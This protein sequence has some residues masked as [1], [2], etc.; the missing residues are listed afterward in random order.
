M[1]GDSASTLI[2]SVKHFFSGTMISRL[3]GLLRDISMAF[4]FGTQESVA[5]FLMAFRFAHLLRRLFGEGAMQ[6]AFTPFF[7]KLKLISPERASRFFIDLLATLS[8][9]L[10][11]IVIVGMAGCSVILRNGW[12]G[13]GNAQVLT[14]TLIMLPSLLFICLFGLNASLLQCARSYFLPSVS[15]VLFNLVWTG[16]ALLLA[17]VPVDE[18]MPVLSGFIIIACAC[19]WGITVPATIRLLK[20][21]DSK[22]FWH[23]IRLFSPDIKQLL[24]PLLLAIVG[25]SAAQINN[26]MDVIFA[27]YASSE[28]PAYLWYAIRLQQL[29][30]ALFGVGV[31]GALLPPLSRALKGGNLDL[32][33]GH[34]SFAV[35]RCT[36]LM[37]PMTAGIFL[38]GGASIQLLYG[39][40]GFGQESIEGTTACL[41]GYSIG[42]LPMTL[43]L[44]LA[45]AF[46]AQDNFRIPTIASLVSMSVN[47]LL[48]FWFIMGLGLGAAS[49]ALSTSLSA[50]VNVIILGYY[51]R[52]HAG[53]V[54]NKKFGVSMLKTSCATLAAATACAWLSVSEFLPEGITMHPLAYI[55]IQS[56][57]FTTVFFSVAYA[58]EAEDAF[59]WR[60]PASS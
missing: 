7:E 42:L 31:S 58:I 52:D 28:G 35:R 2:R 47:I 17:N 14:Y 60:A 11:I 51:L 4:A 54:I 59:L 44:V 25:V 1:S 39:Y 13:E 26:A 38:L 53:H 6:S 33:R 21:Y 43:V 48:N 30:L 24:P 19:Q 45:P 56:A 3:S 37:L 8:T 46:Y 49:V 57:L 34:L 16:A 55:L 18:A 32:F 23:R 27:R 10:L 36:A 5:A 29:P 50:I 15:P 20:S 22:A 12:V 40:G 41:W 9:L